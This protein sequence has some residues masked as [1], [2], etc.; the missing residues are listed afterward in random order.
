MN[1]LGLAC[2]RCDA[3]GVCWALGAVEPRVISGG[4]RSGGDL[5]VY[6]K[7]TLPKGRV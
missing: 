1:D 2:R 6:K 7:K 4:G 5:M 3:D